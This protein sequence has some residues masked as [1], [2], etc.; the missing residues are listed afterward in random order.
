[1]NLLATAHLS[2]TGERLK[3]I[4]LPLLEHFG[5][6]FW[7]PAE[8]PFEVCIGAILTQNTAWTNV[9][10][11]ISALKGARV[12]TMEGIEAIETGRLAELIRPAGYYN[13]KSARIKGFVGWLRECHNG[14]L[15]VLFNGEWRDL[16]QELLKVRGIGPETCDAILLYAGNKPTFVVDA[17]TRRLFHRLGLLPVDAGYDE[18]RRL[19]MEHLPGD[20]ALFNEYHALIV[21]ECKAFCRTRPLCAGCPLAPQCPTSLSGCRV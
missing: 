6:R 9:E 16:R 20:A 10:K 11:A 13:V 19:F 21:E 1:M 3:A 2:P 12:L 14:S 7:W 8:T 15:D 5:P 18:T 4:F 17:Y